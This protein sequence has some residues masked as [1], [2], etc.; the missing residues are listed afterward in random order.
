MAEGIKELRKLDTN[1]GTFLH[2][3]I[4]LANEQIRHTGKKLKQYSDCKQHPCKW[5]T[6]KK[7]IYTVP[8]RTKKIGRIPI[9]FP[10][11]MRNFHAIF[12]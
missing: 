3:G 1:G 9:C 8:F 5:R 11:T 12:F 2:T 10:N 4:E 6:F 7:K